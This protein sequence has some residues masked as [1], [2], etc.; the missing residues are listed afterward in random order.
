M[1]HFFLY[2]ALLSPVWLQV[3]YYYIFSGEVLHNVPYGPSARNYLDVYIPRKAD[4]NKPL[5][6]MVF[7]SGGMWIIGYKAWGAFMGKVLAANGVICIMPDYRN[8]P[9]V[10]SLLSLLFAVCCLL[11]AVCC[12]LS[13]VYCLLPT[14]CSPPTG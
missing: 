1:F 4:D 5:P 14:V 11:S 6:V 12:L 9:Q 3:G 2:V 8:F 7:Y 13:T 10:P